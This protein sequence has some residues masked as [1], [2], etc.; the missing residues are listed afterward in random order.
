MTLTTITR[1]GLTFMAGL[2]LVAAAPAW[3]QASDASDANDSGLASATLADGQSNK[4]IRMLE[5]QL[6]SAPGDP[7]LL[8]NL[9]IAHAQTGN[10]AEALRRFEAALASRD[11]VELDTAN[12]RTTNSRR[13]ARKAI[14]MLERGEFRPAPSQTDQLTLRD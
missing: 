3:A 13:L 9:G 14:A 11:I 4:A 7:A 1:T 8:I 12:G 10:D 5:A 6:Q 2:G